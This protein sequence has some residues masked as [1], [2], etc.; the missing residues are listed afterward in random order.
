MTALLALALLAAAPSKPPLVYA[1]TDAAFVETARADLTDLQRYVT[2]MAQVMA[3]VEANRALFATPTKTVYS[4]EEKQTLLST[5]GSLFGYFSA[6]EGLRQRYWG[7]I[8]VPPTDIRHA[9]GFVMTHAALT[10]VLAHGLAFTALTINNSQLE[11]IFDEANDEYGVP[12]GA[13]AAFK[14][15][16][17]HL[18][19]TTQLVTG[20]AWALTVE[21]QLKA[22]KLLDE[23]GVK[24]GWTTMQA[25]SK[26]ARAA[27]LD[28]GARLFAGNLADIMKDSTAQAVFPLQKRFAEW[29]G[30]TRVAR[31]GQPLIT[32]R[33][34]QTLVL[35]RL[36]PGD[37]LVSRQ[38]WFLSNIG[39]PGFW[40]HALL[41]VGAAK[42]LAAW[43]D[44][45]E[46]SAWA[47]AQPEKASSFSELLARRY[48]AKWQAYATGADDQGHAPLRVIEAI[49]EGVSF[50]SADHAFGVDYLAALR[51]RLSKLN[52]AKAIERAFRYQGRPYDFD[53][54]F[55]SDTSLVCTELVYKAYQPSVGEPGLR[56][57]LVDVAGRRTLPANELIKRFDLEH[58]T[59]TRQLDFVLFVD[60]TEKQH[61][62]AASDEA[63]LRA[64]WKRVKW[65]V[66]QQ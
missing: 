10:A 57:P 20:D 41:Y 35:P 45:P 60:A 19:T 31:V 44:D 48:P 66:A 62:V 38:N 9:W 64:S 4:P 2:G 16:A 42:D 6:T 47:K 30:D 54:D 13:F 39:L 37:V 61:R 1:L 40:P 17:V 34:W 28:R 65:D 51:P 24:W 25:D 32:T 63:A 12:K 8:K 18:A 36:E 5:W 33:D 46:L 29:A 56:L 50:T 11:T 14:L 22:R 3:R 15:K 59:P 55:F 27:L 58:E 52:K 53:F 23:P 21:P 43:G 7:F 49:S 26:A